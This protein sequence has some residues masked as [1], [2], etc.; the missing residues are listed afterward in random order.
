MLRTKE[1]IQERITQIVVEAANNKDI[2][3]QEDTGLWATRVINEI[4]QNVYQLCID[5]IEARRRF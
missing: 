4:V 2:K 3:W 5:E 1:Q